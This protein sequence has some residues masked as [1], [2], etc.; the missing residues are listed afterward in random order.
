MDVTRGGY[1]ARKVGQSAAQKVSHLE[2]GS[3]YADLLQRQY[4]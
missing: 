1:A 3:F 4:I 2:G